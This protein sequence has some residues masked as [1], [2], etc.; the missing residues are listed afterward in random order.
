MH[1]S[2]IKPR[3][4]I[5]HYT[6]TL[7]RT[8][9][10][11]RVP[12]AAA[13]AGCMF[14]VACSPDATDES[15]PSTS[16]AS[17]PGGLRFVDV[18]ESAGLLRPETRTWG[19][20]WSDYDL[21]GDPDLF[22]GRHKGVPY[23]FVNQSGSYSE[24]NPESIEQFDRHA[25][26]WGEANND[27]RPDLYCTRGA[28]K[29][30]GIG[31]NELLVQVDGGFDDV[32]FD[33][34]VTDKLGRGRLANWLDYDSDNDLDLFV[35]NKFREG[36]GNVL[37]RKDGDHFTRVNAGLGGELS[38][39]NSTWADWDVDGDPDLLVL[40]YGDRSAVAYENAGGRFERTTLPAL[41]ARA[42]Q[43]AA[44]GDYD[45]DGWPDLH[46]VD[47]KG[48][49]LLHNVRGTLRSVQR[50]PMRQ[51]RVSVW[52]DVENDGD[53][54]LFVAQGA[55]GKN[56]SDALNR[57]EFLIVQYEGGFRKAWVPPFRAEHNGDAD[58][59]AAADHNRDGKVDVLVTNGYRQ[60]PGTYRLFENRSQGGGWITLQLRGVPA[61]PFG[62]GARVTV[63]AGELTY[64]RQLTDAVDFRSQSETGYVVLGVGDVGKAEVVVRWLDGTMDCVR[65]RS[66][67]VVRVMQG[68]HPCG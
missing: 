23:L 29:G 3:P 42:W 62:L 33:Y 1:A 43:S 64:R 47:S 36:A 18:T 52:L 17:D 65:G 25:C 22:V 9:L 12:L 35:A 27:G 68:D 26:A 57:S 39:I 8:L 13:L 32:S 34:G 63:H 59:V 53:L 10:F 30:H 46:V 61:N 11:A 7:L 50:F 2:S 19:A 6:S 67:S 14:V 44:W 31:P 24:L 15:G 56:P 20:A 21:D 51:G 16:A 28:R 54:D 48:S 5:P 66:E 60:W 45:G 40:Q 55:R 49:L 38:S 41:G 4:S 58:G 37:F